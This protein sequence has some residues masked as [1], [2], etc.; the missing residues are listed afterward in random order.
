MAR[1]V[2]RWFPLKGKKFEKAIKNYK[3]KYDF[4]D[5]LPKTQSVKNNIVGQNV[6]ILLAK[7]KRRK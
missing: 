6:Q 1:F 2:N 5:T 3:K 7:K 4:V